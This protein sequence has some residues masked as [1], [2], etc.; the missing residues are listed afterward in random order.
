MMRKQPFTCRR[1]RSAKR[2]AVAMMIAMTLSP[3]GRPVFQPAV[4][5]QQQTAPVSQGFNITAGDLRFIYEQIL[6]AQDHAAGGALL[7]PGPNQVADPQLPRGLRTVDGSFNNLVPGQTHFGQAD[8]VFPRLLTPIFKPAEAL[9]RDPDDAGPQAAGQPT[10]YQQKA[11]F[12]SDSQPRVASNL[13]L[14][15]T[16]SNP[17]ALAAASNPCGSGGFF[18]SP[19]GPADPDSGALFIP[20]ITPDFGLSAP[21][22][23][24]FVFFGQF[25]DHGLDLV[26]KGG[27]TVIMPLNA[28]DPLVAGPDH[29]FGNADDIPADQRLMV[30]ARATNQP[31]PD[32]ILGTADDV[33][34]SQNTTTPWVDQNQTYTSHPSHQVFLREYALNAQGKPIQTGLMLD[35]GFCAPRPT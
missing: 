31:G 17:A 28:D 11:G 26:T 12:V 29:I 20:N 32:G 30:M 23:L 18:C 19:A 16:A 13:I 34:E 4:Q 35:G 14:D 15:Q 7:G 33:Q 2:W 6:V 5:A 1:S 22:N 21:F 3:I 27:G 8:L 24:M 9:R 25:F 10:S